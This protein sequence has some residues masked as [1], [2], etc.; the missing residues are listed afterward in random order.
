MTT[1][2]QTDYRD[3]TTLVAIMLAARRSGDRDLERYARGK[4]ADQGIRVS[5]AREP[6]Q[7]VDDA[8]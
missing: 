7:E 6:R 1:T 2:Q 8:Q 4:L 3:I 5:I